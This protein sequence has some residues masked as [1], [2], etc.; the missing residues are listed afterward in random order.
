MV[1]NGI[2]EPSTVASLAS[3]CSSPRIGLL[4]VGGGCVFEVPGHGVLSSGAGAVAVNISRVGVLGPRADR[5]KWGY[6]WP[7]YMV[8]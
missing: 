4:V 2:S 1:G 3:W 6:T 8:L 5:Y 7:L